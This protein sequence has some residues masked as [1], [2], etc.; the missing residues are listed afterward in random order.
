MDGGPNGWFR[1][2]SWLL[3]EVFQDLTTVD[4]PHDQLI[5]VRWSQVTE[6]ETCD[7][8]A[9]TRKGATALAA[10]LIREHR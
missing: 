3:Q 7:C 5:M 1:R 6:G 4:K 2:W 8:S 10:P 9:K